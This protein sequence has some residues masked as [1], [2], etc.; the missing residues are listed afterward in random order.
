MAKLTHIDGLPMAI[1]QRQNNTIKRNYIECILCKCGCGWHS[2][3]SMSSFL[4]IGVLSLCIFSFIGT[5]RAFEVLQ[6]VASGLGPAALQNL[7]G[8]NII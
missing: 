5:P 3:P 6:N 2:A 7:H 8:T 4:Y 1:T